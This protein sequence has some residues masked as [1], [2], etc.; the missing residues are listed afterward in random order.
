MKQPSPSWLDNTLRNLTLYVKRTDFPNSNL[1]N[2]S[3]TRINTAGSA[4]GSSSQAAGFDNFRKK[5]RQNNKGIKRQTGGSSIANEEGMPDIASTSYNFA[6]L[7][8][9]STHIYSEDVRRVEIV[10]K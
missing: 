6:K 4:G 7:V 8:G 10:Q 2:N 5:L 9:S 1:M 3:Q